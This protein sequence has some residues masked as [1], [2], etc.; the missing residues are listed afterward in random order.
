MAT[1]CTYTIKSLLTTEN[2]FTGI[3][4][5]RFKI[6]S[7]AQLGSSF[8]TAVAIQKIG[9]PSTRINVNVSSYSYASGINTWTLAG[10]PFGANNHESGYCELIITGL[11]NPG[12]NYTSNYMMRKWYSNTQTSEG[13]I[14]SLTE[15]YDDTST[16][17]TSSK[18]TSDFKFFKNGPGTYYWVVPP[19]V[20]SIKYFI[21]GGGGAGGSIDENNTTAA[22]RGG[23]GGG[24][25][26]YN[27]SWAVTP[28]ETLRIIVGSGGVSS[29]TS[30]IGPSGT[31]SSISRN[32]GLG[33]T[34]TANPGT[35][36]LLAQGG[37]S[38]AGY[39]IT[40]S[41]LAGGGSGT[42]SPN[43][44]Y[45]PQN[46]TAGAGGWGQ[47]ITIGNSELPIYSVGGGGGGAS[48]G[49]ANGL[50]AGWGGGGV[51][52]STGG[53]LGGSGADGAVW[54]FVESN[55]ERASVPEPR[56]N[57][58]NIFLLCEQVNGKFTIGLNGINKGQT[59]ALNWTNVTIKVYNTE[60]GS[61]DGTLTTPTYTYDS[62]TQNNFWQF[63]S[64]FGIY[65]GFTSLGTLKISISA[66][67]S[68]TTVTEN[69]WW[70]PQFYE[71][72]DTV[73]IP[74]WCASCQTC[75]GY[76]ETYT[77]GQ[78]TYHTGASATSYGLSLS[79]VAPVFELTT[80]A[81]I[82]IFNTP[83]AAYTSWT[84]ITPEGST[85]PFTYSH[86]MPEGVYITPIFNYIGTT[87][88][89]DI[90]QASQHYTSANYSTT[91]NVVPSIGGYP[92]GVE[93]YTISIK[94]LGSVLDTTPDITIQEL[95]PV[96]PG[97]MA[98]CGPISMGGVDPSRSI[99][100]AL[101]YVTSP[102]NETITLN[103]DIVRTFAGK[104]TSGSAVVMPTDF[105]GKIGVG[106]Y[107]YEVP[108]IYSFIPPTGVTSISGV[109][110][111]GGGAGSESTCWRYYGGCG[112]YRDVIANNIY[113]HTVEPMISSTSVTAS[114]RLTTVTAGGGG[115]GGG[116]V[117]ANDVQVQP[118]NIYTIYVGSG[119]VP[120]VRGG[121]GASYTCCH[122]NYYYDTRTRTIPCRRIFTTAAGAGGSSGFEFKCGYVIAFG[123]CGGGQMAATYCACATSSRINSAPGGGFTIWHCRGSSPSTNP[124]TY[125]G[126]IGGS[127][128]IPEGYAY[129]RGY[130]NGSGFSGSTLMTKYGRSR[131]GG[132]GGAAGFCCVAYTYATPTKINSILSTFTATKTVRNGHHAPMRTSCTNQSPYCNSYI[133][134]GYSGCGGSAKQANTY[135]LNASLVSKRLSSKPAHD[136]GYDGSLTA[137]QC[138]PNAW[139]G[140]IVD[141]GIGYGGGG[142][143]MAPDYTYSGAGGGGTEVFGS[144]GG[145]S[146]M[147]AGGGGA[148]GFGGGVGGLVA[149]ISKATTG[150]NS[151]QFSSTKPHG[152]KYGGG[153]GGGRC[154]R[155]GT[156]AT[157]LCGAHLTTVNCVERFINTSKYAGNGGSGVVR[158]IWPGHIR[159]FPNTKVGYTNNDVPISASNSPDV[160]KALNATITQATAM[161]IN[162][163]NS[164]NVLLSG[165]WAADSSYN[166]G[167][168]LWTTAGNTQRKV[169]AVSIGSLSAYG[170]LSTST[171]TIGAYS[172]DLINVYNKFT[173]PTSGTW[174]NNSTNSLYF[175]FRGT[176]TL[177]YTKLHSITLGQ[178]TYGGTQQLA[179][180][181]TWTNYILSDYYVSGALPSTIFYTTTQGSYVY[182][183]FKFTIP[184]ANEYTLG[185]QYTT[186]LDSYYTGIYNWCVNVGPKYRIIINSK[187]T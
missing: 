28:G 15:G 98:S 71:Y 86:N 64:N 129:T 43:Y 180:S 159:K 22:V 157:F 16:N 117:W 42:T 112:I 152:G 29:Y 115:G 164:Q 123:G 20:T 118:G 142:G 5:T 17:F 153:G 1:F 148:A 56:F 94:L 70:K 39:T 75:L 13:E 179:P 82:N 97:T 11:P 127:G 113:C 185:W 83:T 111:G 130:E 105:Y 24:Q 108:G 149:N 77:Y 171:V 58:Y 166:T 174:N 178:E 150:S 99:S 114:S 158:I 116:L 134:M 78:Y 183:W 173:K 146:T 41:G 186:L 187:Y 181:Y 60:T 49:G 91:F 52:V 92:E 26:L 168:D 163:V 89:D 107:L 61:I 34:I 85:S 18:L 122:P 177:D 104:S 31:A 137:Y 63:P 3:T 30:S 53:A 128:G 151:S 65:D 110:V 7:A 44:G 156:G 38:G 55:N 66:T 103:D 170:S 161:A 12:A 4:V 144:A 37:T 57:D 40:M 132:G 136:A 90:H 131:A 145:T 14:T 133:S 50:G 125:G 8:I 141:G 169:D 80:T 139:N 2:Y 33:S 45:L 182:N 81:A 100:A 73:Y 172:Y 46:G 88:P 143:G 19:D 120:E 138:T 184:V 162:S 96:F 48:T 154:I 140:A 87:T 9:D 25:T 54:I 124:A 51:S 27:A 69:Y 119:G 76:Y 35:G 67:I 102:I 68:G 160:T 176:T 6:A 23:G 175:C 165:M 47:Y 62:A 126:G 79:P 36:G 101:A 155:T 109:A 84:S 135:F 21:V 32:F 95:S 74:S 121:S 59:A 147:Q 106:G 72:T 93:K 10:T 167:W